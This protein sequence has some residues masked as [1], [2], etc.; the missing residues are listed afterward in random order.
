MEAFLAASPPLADYKGNSRLS[1]GWGQ[2]RML[3][4]PLGENKKLAASDSVC[5]DDGDN[6]LQLSA[7]SSDITPKHGVTSNTSPDTRDVNPAVDT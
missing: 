3:K 4:V 6:V 2:S 1:D 7:I 5:A